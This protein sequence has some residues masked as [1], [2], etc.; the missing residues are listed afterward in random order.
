MNDRPRPSLIDFVLAVLN[1]V[2]IMLLLGSLL[3]FL[4]DVFYRGQ[5]SGRLHWVLALFVMATVLI[6]RIAMEQ[7]EA[8]AGGYAVALGLVTLAALERFVEFGGAFKS[9]STLIN[10]GLM[11]LVWWAAHR[12]TKECTAAEGQGPPL[13]GSLWE[14]AWGRALTGL[15][16]RRQEQEA[17]AGKPEE[18]GLTVSPG[19]QSADVLSGRK[20]RLGTRH[21]PGVWVLY[22]SLV[23][24]PLFGLGELLGG[25]S[26]VE[27][28][29]WLLLLLATYLASAFA[30]LLST[31][32]LNLR[33][34]VRAR[35]LDMP[36][37]M[38]A[39]WLI[40]GAGLIIVALAVAW[41]VP[42]PTPIYIGARISDWVTSPRTTS[43]PVAPP[44]EAATNSRPGHPGG[45]RTAA[46]PARQEDS[47]KPEPVR[48]GKEAGQPGTQS[49]T[50]ASSGTRGETQRGGT[51][52]A[53][54]PGHQGMT[55]SA[56]RVAQDSPPAS[57]S[58]TGRSVTSQQGAAGTG[59][60]P[61]GSTSPPGE[62][63]NGRAGSQEIKPQQASSR[64]SGQQGGPGQSDRREDAQSGQDSQEGVHSSQKGGV[65]NPSARSSSAAEEGR[66]SIQDS[67]GP[68]TPSAQPPASGQFGG[69]QSTPLGGT[70]SG[71]RFPGEQ[72]SSATPPNQ[73][74]GIS[75]PRSPKV[76][77]VREVGQW[78]AQGF[79]WLIFAI[80]LLVLA[81]WVWRNRAM[82]LQWLSDLAG[83]LR[84]FWQSL[85]GGH[86]TSKS[87]QP[88]P[89]VPAARRPRFG[90]FPN[91]FRSTRWRQMDRAKLV[92]YIFQAVEAWA[93]EFA[94][95]RE[96]FETPL[97]FVGRLAESLP[98]G[99][100]LLRHLGEMYA[101]LAY[102]PA[103]L[104]DLPVDN[105][106]ALWELLEEKARL[107]R[108]AELAAA[109][110]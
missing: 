9:F 79:K 81:V 102:S 98:E 42:R 56:G 86:I 67:R 30:L 63:P 18:E 84:E 2:L 48:E 20:K 40:W 24:L 58:Q 3:F 16:W 12:L 37:E 80:I 72:P 14:V 53:G 11:V 41:I 78:L 26:R 43:S 29:G 104:P 110:S 21:T 62:R 5:Y 49:K 101:R 15:G 65:L 4:V 54:A 103:G 8:R 7:D 64:T 13:E 69:M 91:P 46:T 108:T 99:Q 60:S 70:S 75:L 45:D 105:L 82:V 22:V 52:P 34:Y 33:R 39:T 17:E 19:E 107:A 28:R 73:P 23:A 31:S 92:L 106:R 93:S 38:T 96:E 83:L 36:E 50:A 88:V 77:S 109:K 55:E 47:A 89:E 61:T 95:G 44:G 71:P 1:P 87:E 100:I 35:R 10:L 85:F 90:D 76:P 57:S 74:Q 94:R 51:G 97:E 6:T 66:S 68:T 25:A 27:R 32:F 59:G